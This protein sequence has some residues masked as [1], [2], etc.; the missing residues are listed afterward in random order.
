ML[1]SLFPSFLPPCLTPDINFPECHSQLEFELGAIF[2][3][4]LFE[5]GRHPQ[6]LQGREASRERGREGKVWLAMRPN[7]DKQQDAIGVHLA[8][9]HRGFKMNDIFIGLPPRQNGKFLAPFARST[10]S[11]PVSCTLFPNVP[12]SPGEATESDNL[13]F[14]CQN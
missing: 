4:Y 11:P 9:C 2:Q 13:R 3:C 5:T 6:A 12:S 7:Q 8:P 1:L 10:D 14:F